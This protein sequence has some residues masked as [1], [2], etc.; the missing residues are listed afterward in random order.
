[1][2]LPDIKVRI[3][4][5]RDLSLV[6]AFSLKFGG[7]PERNNQIQHLEEDVHYNEDEDH[8]CQ[9][10]D[11]LG[12]E[13]GGISVEEALYRARDAVPPIAVS[14][15]GEE[16]ECEHTPRAVDAVDRD[17]AEILR[18]GDKSGGFHSNCRVD[19]NP[20][21]SEF[22][23][24]ARQEVTMNGPTPAHAGREEKDTLMALHNKV[25][26]AEECLCLL[27][28]SF[29]Y[30]SSPHLL[31]C[32][33]R[34][35]DLIDSMPAVAKKVI[36][37][38]EED[39]NLKPYIPV[40]DHILI[41][42]ENIGRLCGK[43]ERKIRE[44]ILFSH[45]AMEE[46]TFLFQRLIDLLRPTAELILA[47]NEILA[48]YVEESEEDVSKRA[49][50]YATFHEDRLIEGVCQPVAAPIYLGMLDSIKSI[51][52]HARQIATKLT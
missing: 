10:A 21:V 44:D 47:R 12:N 25:K 28:T 8:V 27:Q 17:R 31:E 24:C 45:K 26:E 18:G 16:T 11:D 52:W 34:V 9:C 35:T 4:L 32:R 40:P 19:G 1:M 14:A 30:Y 38:A 39:P 2:A 13:L 48:N 46:T 6:K 33:R 49:T 36:D 41:I 15:V 43:M 23:P 7:D 51:A 42:G 3:C 50:E 37:L 5:H 22:Y 29:I 20:D